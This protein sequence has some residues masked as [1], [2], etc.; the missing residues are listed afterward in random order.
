MRSIA[1]R[2]GRTKVAICHNERSFICE[3][4]AEQRDSQIDAIREIPTGS[5]RI[6]FERWMF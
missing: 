5:K 1:I 3:G 2:V 6:L 4:K